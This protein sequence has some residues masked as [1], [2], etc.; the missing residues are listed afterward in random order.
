MS[1]SKL[2]VLATTLLLTWLAPTPSVLAQAC[3]PTCR[4]G[5]ACVAGA[6][7]SPCNPAC[8]AGEYCRADG[9]CLPMSS[10]EQATPS[11]ARVPPARVQRNGRRR[12]ITTTLGAAM[13]LGLVGAAARAEARDTHAELECEND[14]LTGFPIYDCTSAVERDLYLPELPLLGA[15][16]LV[17]TSFWVPSLRAGTFANRAGYPGGRALRIVGLV[18][19]LLTTVAN[20]TLGTALFLEPEERFPPYLYHLSAGLGA[21]TLVAAAA[22]AFLGARQ[23]RFEAEDVWTVQL[24]PLRDGAALAL[25]GRFR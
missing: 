12:G 10:P 2:A 1:V 9:Q 6:C 4:E 13:Y 24:S 19:Y 8:A 5:Y 15:A 22:D 20:A 16:T 23:A 7:I 3:E 17:L 14:R 18:G 25:R 21:I 11:R